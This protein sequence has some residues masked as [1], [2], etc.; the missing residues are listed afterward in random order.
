VVSALTTIRNAGVVRVDL[1]GTVLGTLISAGGTEIDS[2]TAVNTTISSGGTQS[3]NR[4]ASVTTINNHGLQQVGSGG[5]AI[6][7]TINSG[8]KQDLVGGKS[9][10]TAIKSA[11]TEIAKPRPL[12]AA[13]PSTWVA[14]FRSPPAV[15]RS[16]PSPRLGVRS[17]WRMAARWY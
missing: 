6:V 1:S 9:I 5:T 11:G 4:L 13:R 17:T 10:A 16:T 2:G 14:C 7:T 8:S 12:P 15:P 3:V